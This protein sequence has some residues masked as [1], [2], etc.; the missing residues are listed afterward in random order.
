MVDVVV[1]SVVVVDFAEE[2]ADDVTDDIRVVEEEEEGESD[3]GE[4]RR[5][6]EHS[7]SGQGTH[8]PLAK[9]SLG[10]HA[11]QPFLE[12]A[13]GCSQMWQAVPLKNALE[14]HGTQSMTPPTGYWSNGQAE[15]VPFA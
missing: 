3:R 5:V 14:E 9:T 6:V 2:A 11:E 7:S 8:R 13:K 10:R 12:A 4:R 15:Q 1:V